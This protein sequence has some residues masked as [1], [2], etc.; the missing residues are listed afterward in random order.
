MKVSNW[1]RGLCP[2]LGPACL[3]LLG[4]AAW[5]V[6]AQAFEPTSAGA[7]IRQ[8]ADT[9][10]G[11]EGE[12]ALE[13][14]PALQPSAPAGT[15]PAEGE[16]AFV[17]NEFTFDGA[18][19]DAEQQRVDAF[20]APWRGRSVTLAQL[21]ALRDELT[22]VLY[23]GGETLVRV[24]LP[25]QTVTAGV[26]RFGI[27]RG[28]V[29]A[30]KVENGSKVSTPRLQAILESTSET[31]P[32]LREI[33]RNM[34]VVEG[35]PGVG[36]V[37]STLATGTEAGGTV[38]GV[39]VTPADR[40]Y[41]AATIDNSGSRQ[42]GW[43]RVGVSGGVNNVLGLGDQLQGTVY[44][45][46]R[47]MQT[48]SGEDGRTRLGRLSYDM[49]TG[50]GASRAGMAYS[51]VDYKLG[52]AFSGL[53]TGK[54]DVASLYGSS[55]VI[56][57]ANASL[58]LGASM[59]AWFTTDERL[60]NIL[61][62]RQRNYVA[63]LRAD[64]NFYGKW[65]ARRNATQYSFVTSYGTTTQ[66]EYDYSSTQPLYVDRRFNF[67]KIEPSATY[68]QAL[69]STTQATLAVHGQWASRSLN[70]SQ[71]LG[72]GGPSAVRAY[73]QN[74][75]SVD[76]GVIV[77]VGVSQFIPP[78]PGAAVQVFYDD[79]RGR[80]RSDG[81]MAGASV[82]L[83]GYGIGASYSGKRVSAQI[84]YAM[85][86]GPAPEHAARQQTWVTLTASI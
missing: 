39:D 50:I 63:S 11:I 20:L 8:N 81:P 84:S 67:L 22:T 5:H 85:R 4:L 54:A 21:H 46:P 69:T 10:R 1:Y 23:N 56:R 32:T 42:A 37:S 35:I 9:S 77:S 12:S 36:S 16:L 60:D 53:G 28:H 47:F 59:E 31:T 79:A 61:D 17:V 29:E 57:T 15:A 6:S 66:K 48:S 78:L 49:L 64:G 51:H 80:I 70:G 7:L 62:S 30:L 3:P 33:E 18:L 38:V 27:E 43:R 24:T 83:Q 25:P 73:D 19:S 68:I 75:A 82:R 41:A 58:D 13:H 26:V 45:T 52:E 14:A 76:D 40:F 74:A 86:T 44:F 2:R 71:R 55:P 65:G 72:L 34:R